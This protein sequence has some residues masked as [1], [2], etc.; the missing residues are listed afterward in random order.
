MFE[1]SLWFIFT[2][3]TT[4]K[5]SSG[6]MGNLSVR[7]GH[8]VLYKLKTKINLTAQVPLEK[9]M[10]PQK[11]GKSTTSKKSEI[12]NVE[13]PSKTSSVSAEQSNTLPEGEQ[14]MAED[15]TEDMPPHEAQ[16]GAATL[17][18]L[19]AREDFKR[20]LEAIMDATK[21]LTLPLTSNI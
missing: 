12:D 5:S 19:E 1:T 15:P 8:R 13:Q 14:D 9:E 6:I 3:F 7:K 4:S 20:Q 18:S 10:S 2:N 21:V 11:K 16:M 17:E